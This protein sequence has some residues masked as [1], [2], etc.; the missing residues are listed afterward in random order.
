MEQIYPDD[1]SE[2][3]NED[4]NITNDCDDVVEG[5]ELF[6]TNTVVLDDVPKQ[7][8]SIST[9]SRR[10]STKTSAPKKKIG[11]ISRTLFYYSQFTVHIYTMSKNDLL[12]CV[13]Y[14]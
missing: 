6:S 5:V 10:R 8:F 7:Q 12:V 3:E 4:V 1:Y 9:S 2:E 11:T 14:S 13:L